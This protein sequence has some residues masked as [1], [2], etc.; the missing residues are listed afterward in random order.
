MWSADSDIN[1][2]RIAR[3]RALEETQPEAAFRLL[4][5][6]AD[7]G[8]AWAMEQV[9]DRLETGRG[10]AVDVDRALD[11]YNRA[12]GAG[13]WTATLEVARLL[14]G[15]ERFDEAEAMLEQGLAGG[16]VPSSFWL[17][18]YRYKRSPTLATGRDVRPLLS[19]AADQGHPGAK[20]ILARWMARGR[21]GVREIPA[22]C[23][24][25]LWLSREIQAAPAA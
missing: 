9:G 22:G 10:T 7:A 23:R 6:A 11:Y 21:F 16:F 3:A 14:V 13:S 1:R 17:A 18:W 5:E 20:L 15:L 8:S 19:H 24:R 25:L 2:E 4:C 12:I